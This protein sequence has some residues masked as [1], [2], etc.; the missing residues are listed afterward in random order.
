M[1]CPDIIYGTITRLGDKKFRITCHDGTT[2]EQTCDDGAWENPSAG[3]CSPPTSEAP[4]T[5]TSSR[6]IQGPATGNQNVY[7]IM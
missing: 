2:F 6:S 7:K 5:A 4:V 3:P 1:S